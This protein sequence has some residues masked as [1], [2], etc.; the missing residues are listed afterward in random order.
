MAPSFCIELCASERQQLLAIARQSI[1]TGLHQGDALKVALHELSVTLASHMGVFVTLMQ[2]ERLR[3]CIGS[4]Q[5]SEPLAQSVADSAFGAAFQ[6]PRFPQLRL[7]ELDGIHIEI[8]ILSPMT[9][10]AVQSR[11][12]LLDNLRPGSDGLL[13]ED[14]RYR[15]T[16]LPKVWEQLPS[17]DTFLEKLFDKAGL[18]TDHW[19]PTLRLYRYHTVCLSEAE[20]ACKPI[21]SER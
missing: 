18:P 14:G 6:D 1:H 12:D 19:S 15:A 13:L 10:L 9:P 2:G 4:M 3:G 16:F 8:S 17:P 21:D 5:A 11:E 20:V 7:H